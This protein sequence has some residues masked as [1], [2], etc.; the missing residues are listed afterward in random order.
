MPLD[1]ACPIDF[2]DIILFPSV[3]LLGKFELIYRLVIGVYAVMT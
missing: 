3:F 2:G 1:N